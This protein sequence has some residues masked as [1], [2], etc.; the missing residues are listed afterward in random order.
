M[1]SNTY[2]F[3]FKKEKDVDSIKELGK[4]IT[5]LEM[6]EQNFEY[7]KKHGHLH[8][9]GGDIKTVAWMAIM[10]DVLHNVTDGIA[11]G[12]A[13]TSSLSSGFASSIAIFCHELP[14]ELGKKYILSISL[15]EFFQKWYV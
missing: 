1:I 3:V 12:A 7:Q 9:H 6:N 13:F 11:I 14:H 2:Q 15:Y 10:G 8:S 5:T 4:M